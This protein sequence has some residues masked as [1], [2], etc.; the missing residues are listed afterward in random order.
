MESQ[1]GKKRQA[2]GTEKTLVI[3]TIS[4]IYSATHEAAKVFLDAEL[5]DMSG[6]VVEMMV[7]I[8]HL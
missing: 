4:Y 6:L 8:R 5:L 3:S 2:Q 7:P 1:I